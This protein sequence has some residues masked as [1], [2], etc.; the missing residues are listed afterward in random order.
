MTETPLTEPFSVAGLRPVGWSQPRDAIAKA[1]RLVD[2]DSGVI[3]TLFE[4]PMNPDTPQV[5]GYGSILADTTAFGVE[6]FGTLNGS[7]STSRQQAAAGA[8]GEAVERYAAR[9]VP[10]GDLVWAS[11]AELGEN[12]IDPVDLVLYDEEQYARPDFPFREPARADILPWVEG[13][14]LTRNR[15]VLVPAEAVFMHTVHAGS[16]GFVQQTTNGLACGNTR[17]E[18]VLSGLYEVV[19]RDASMLTWLRRS[20]N[21]TLDLG[22]AKDPGLLAAQ[23]LFETARMRVRLVDITTTG[24]PAVLAMTW[25]RGR[26]NGVPVVSSAANLSLQ[27][28]A[29]SAL[30]ELAQCVPWVISMLDR[31]GGRPRKPLDA[32]TSTEDHV[33]WIVEPERRHLADFL[34]R[35]TQTVMLGDEPFS[36]ADVLGEIR[37]CVSRLAAEELEV[38]VVDVTTPDV[39]E[40]GLSVVRTLVLG[41]IPLYF[42]SGLWRAGPRARAALGAG[43]NHCPHPFP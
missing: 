14:S 11:P 2:S 37:E 17:E 25:L 33:L 9:F 32:L 31:P 19:E 35:S 24:I 26:N 18:A 23:R 27:R 42:G 36:A 38:V 8:L 3:R 6:D 13:H 40:V 10:Y 5:F 34:L 15:T 7:T 43:I 1:L 12:A 4:S 29:R 21:P 30:E 39:A 16:R 22:T 20:E 28:A 41:S